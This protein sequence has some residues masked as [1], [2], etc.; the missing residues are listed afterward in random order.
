M[1]PAFR[2]CQKM[3]AQSRGSE[4]VK[5]SCVCVTFEKV[6]P[7]RSER[8]FRGKSSKQAF[9]ISDNDQ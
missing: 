2:T 8:V 7:Q 1:M 3:F 6:L 5:I 9:S 4:N